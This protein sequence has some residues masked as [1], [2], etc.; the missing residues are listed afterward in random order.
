MQ[1]PRDPT[2]EDFASS[3]LRT[4]SVNSHPITGQPVEGGGGSDVPDDGLRVE[5]FRS[6]DAPDL[7]AFRVVDR[8]GEPLG[9]IAFKYEAMEKDLPARTLARV[10]RAESPRPLLR[11]V[12]AS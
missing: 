12:K 9:L 7:I 10:R 11:L 1:E 8:N 5:R 4:A 6:K 3:L 2:P